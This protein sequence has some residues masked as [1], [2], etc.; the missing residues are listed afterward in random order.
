MFLKQ[1]VEV[2]ISK[3][4][5]ITIEYMLK[6]FANIMETVI[7]LFIGLSVESDLHS[8]NTCFVI[9]TLVTCFA[10]RVMG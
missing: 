6:M 2:N 10:Y 4:S 8:W 7:F 3:K 9:V 1:Y 5:S